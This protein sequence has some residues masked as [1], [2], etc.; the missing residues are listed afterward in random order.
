MEVIKGP[1]RRLDGT[2]RAPLRRSRKASLRNCSPIS[3]RR[4]AKTRCRCWRSYW[5]GFMSSTAPAANCSFPSIGAR[6]HSRARSR[7][8]WSAR[9]RRPTQIRQS[10]RTERRV[11]ALAP[12]PDPVDRGHRS[13]HRRA[14]SPGCAD[15]RNPHGGGAAH[16]SWLGALLATNGHRQGREKGVEGP[17]SPSNRHTRPCSGNGTSSRYG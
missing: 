10:R 6:R 1:L 17:V 4:A 7:R 16:P 5:S 3:R 2:R 13:R 15:V 14:A 8:R 9:S 11:A 12:R